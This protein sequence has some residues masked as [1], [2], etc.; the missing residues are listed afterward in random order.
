MG[1][2]GYLIQCA[3]EQLVVEIKKYFENIPRNVTK[4]VKSKTVK[5]NRVQNYV[6]TP[7]KISTFRLNQPKFSLLVT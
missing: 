3:Y 7:N 6:S 4:T 5:W 1:L 2:V